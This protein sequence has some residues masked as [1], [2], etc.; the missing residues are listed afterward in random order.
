MKPSQFPTAFISYAFSDAKAD[1]DDD[2]DANDD[3][4]RNNDDADDNDDD[5]ADDIARRVVAD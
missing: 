4:S 3:E 1:R 5:D 2:N